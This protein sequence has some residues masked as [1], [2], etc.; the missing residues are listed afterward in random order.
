MILLTGATGFVGSAVLASLKKSGPVR[1]ALRQSTRMAKGALP[2]TVEIID[3]SMSPDQDWSKALAGVST[4][5]HCAARVHVMREKSVNPIADFRR[6]NVE[7]TMKLAKQA[8]QA[9]VKRLVFISS[10]KVNGESTKAGSK[11]TESNLPSP[12]DPYGQSKYEAEMGL[13][14]LAAETGMEIVIVRPPMVYGPGVKANFAALARAV[15][16]GIPLPL[17][18]I[19]NQR[20]FVALDNLVDFIL[21]CVSHAKAANQIFLVSD[22]EDLSTTELVRGM[23][24]SS[25]VTPRLLPIPVWALEI[26]AS[27]LGKRGAVQRLCGNLQIDISK[28]QTLLGWTP[29]ISV[30]EGLR[31]AIA[32]S[33]NGSPGTLK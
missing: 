18:A 19:H 2:E 25:N 4:V 12:Q 28:A 7:G 15:Q 10:I 17:G 23:A 30:D 3:A 33:S 6:V 21:T 5:I 9:G 13:S 11:F 22:G 26:G 8:A 32:P 31:R 20:S 1:I 24:R 14:Q 27:L 29:P 16:R